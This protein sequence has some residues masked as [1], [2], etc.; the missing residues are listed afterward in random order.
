MRYFLV[1]VYKARL[2]IITDYMRSVTILLS[3][4]RDRTSVDCVG[5]GGG[6]AN[7]ANENVTC[8]CYMLGKIPVQVQRDPG[9]DEKT[10]TTSL[11]SN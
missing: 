4:L 7:D 11:I 1:R 10:T 8:C 6:E 9:G 5:G 3:R 2:A